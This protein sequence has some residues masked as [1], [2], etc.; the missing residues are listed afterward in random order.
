MLR[1]RRRKAKNHEDL[2]ARGRRLPPLPDRQPEHL[3]SLYVGLARGRSAA[4][5]VMRVDAIFVARMERSEIRDC[6]ARPPP[7]CA[8]LHAGYESPTYIGAWILLSRTTW[9]QR[10]ISLLSK[11]RAA[12][13]ERC[14]CG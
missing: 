5:A 3:L 9:P 8:A 1:R 7:P 10:A 6:A 2:H 13:A 14:S 4:R 12:A 11:A